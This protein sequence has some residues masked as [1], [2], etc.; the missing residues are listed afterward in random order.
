[1]I[2]FNRGEVPTTI[3]TTVETVDVPVDAETYTVR[4]MWND[5]EWQTDG[6][7]HATVDPHDVAMFRVI[8]E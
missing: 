2:L 8:P 1:V 3:E 6:S 7:L 5:E 4:D